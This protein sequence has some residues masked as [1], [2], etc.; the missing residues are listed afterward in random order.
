[1]SMKKRIQKELAEL[2]KYP[3]AGCSAGCVGGVLTH[4][5]GCISG[6]VDTPYEGGLFFLDIRFPSEYPYKPP[7]IKFVTKIYHPNISESGAICLDILKQ[8]AWSPVLTVSKVLI[9]LTSLLCDPNP[10]DPLVASAA[11]LYKADRAAYNAKVKEWVARYA[12]GH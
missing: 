10:D 12:S 2:T 5:S 9:S 6:P 1:M 7:N 4:W 11:R 3:P 8:T